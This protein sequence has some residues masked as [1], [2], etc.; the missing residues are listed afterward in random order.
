[1]ERIILTIP[2]VFFEDHGERA[3]QLDDYYARRVGPKSRRRLQVALTRRDVAEL[4]S[5]AEHYA[6]FG[7]QDA[8]ENG[9]VCASARATV[10]AIRKQVD[11]DLLAECRI[12]YRNNSAGSLDPIKLEGWP[13]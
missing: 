6:S 12:E 3:C 4:L 10:K 1:M 2:P 11:P 7:G 5:D 9:A 8:F 13:S